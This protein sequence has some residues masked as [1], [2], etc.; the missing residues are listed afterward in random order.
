MAGKV[1]DTLPPEHPLESKELAANFRSLA[2]GT[3]LRILRSLWQRQGA[4]V[5]D[6][7]DE[8]RVSQPLMSWHLRILRRSGMVTTERMGRQVHCV[9]AA[10]IMEEYGTLLAAYL[11]AGDKSPADVVADADMDSLRVRQAAAIH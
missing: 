9:V 3:R 1:T 6:L 11:V 2:D 10:G 8:L 5:T 4:T 7:C